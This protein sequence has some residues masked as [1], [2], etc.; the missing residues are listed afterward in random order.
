MITHVI[1]QS[2]TLNKERSVLNE[3]ITSALF[4]DTRCGIHYQMYSKRRLCCMQQQ[5][6]SPLQLFGSCCTSYCP[7]VCQCQC[8]RRSGTSHR[9]GGGGYSMINQQQQQSPVVGNP[10]SKEFDHVFIMGDLNFRINSTREIVDE[11]LSEGCYDLLQEQD[12]LIWLMSNGN[13]EECFNGLV[14]GT[15]DFPPVRIHFSA[16]TRLCVRL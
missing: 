16:T 7:P 9:H 5:Q 15:I 6:Y 8:R 14:E 4:L 1:S 10:L 11:W 2:T 13:D 3:L 12:Q